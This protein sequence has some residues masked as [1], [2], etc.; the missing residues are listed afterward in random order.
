MVA[1]CGFWTDVV[2]RGGDVERRLIG[3]RITVRKHEI[4]GTSLRRPRRQAPG[5]RRAAKLQG[6][7][8]VRQ[9]PADRLDAASGECD[10]ELTHTHAAIRCRV[11]LVA[12]SCHERA[13]E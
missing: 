12:R 1:F 8:D 7:R 2:G 9:L 13:L 6:R 4:L 3:P 5:R 10:M 11:S